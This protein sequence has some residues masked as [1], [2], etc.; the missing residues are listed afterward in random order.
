M[1]NE[2]INSGNDENVLTLANKDSYLFQKNINGGL[3]LKLR[4]DTV[5]KQ[6]KKVLKKLK[7]SNDFKFHS[8]RHSAITEL[9]KNNVPINIVKEIAGHKSIKTTMIYL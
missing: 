7:L 3:K 1:I 4:A 6:F 9:I 5:S 8:L 2:V